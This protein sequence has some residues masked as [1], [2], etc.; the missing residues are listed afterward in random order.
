MYE[1]EVCEVAPN[2]WGIYLKYKTRK[3]YWVMTPY[4]ESEPSPVPK[5][6]WCYESASHAARGYRPDNNGPFV[7]IMIHHT[8][9]SIT[10][11]KD[12][13]PIW[14]RRKE[15]YQKYHSTLLYDRFNW[16]I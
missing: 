6:R 16:A 13:R 15:V 7:P 2:Q 8:D 1:I 10:E 5:T 11:D 3:D 14:V 4:Y 12:N 9:G